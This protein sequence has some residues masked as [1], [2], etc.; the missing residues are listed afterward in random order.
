[1]A[2]PLRRKAAVN[3]KRFTAGYIAERRDALMEDVGQ[4]NAEMDRFERMYRLDVWES[5]KSAEEQRATL[6]I[7]PD[8]IEKE[9]SLLLSR[10]YQISV[11]PSGNGITE[12]DRA[13]K[14]ERHLYGVT[15]RASIRKRAYHA[16][17]NANCPGAGWIKAVYD[18]QA[19]EDEYPVSVTAPDPRTIYP[20]WDATGER[21]TELCHS[22]ERTRRGIEQEFDVQLDGAPDDPDK[23][24]AWL[25]ECV[26]YTEYWRTETV[27]TSVSEDDELTPEGQEPEEDEAPLVI[28]LAAEDYMRRTA[29]TSA[30]AATG[31]DGMPM[32]TIGD[33]L[34]TAPPTDLQEEE[35]P[36]KSKRAPKR[37]V[38]KIIH[39]IIC[40][41]NKDDEPTVIKAPVIVLGY[42]RIPYF[43]W[44]GIETPMAGNRRWLSMLFPATGG[45]GAKNATGVLQLYNLVVSL[46]LDESVRRIHAP[47]ITD[48]DTAEIDTAPDAI[49]TTKP[50]RNVGYLQPPPVNTSLLNVS[51][52][53][54]RMLDR[55]GPPEVWNGQAFNLSGQA[56]SGLAN[57]YQTRIASK[58]QVIE[59]VLC[60]LY[61]HILCI[62]AFYADPDEGWRAYGTGHYGKFV[63]EA[64]TADDIG[65]QYRVIV[66][67]SSSMPKDEIALVSLFAQLLGNN[68]IS[69]ETFLDQFQKLFGMAADSP[70]DEIE[71]TF[72][73]ML[74]REKGFAERIA[75]AKAEDF[76]A[77]LQGKAGGVSLADIERAENLRAMQPPPPP[78]PAPPVM[79]RP[80][81]PGQGSGLPPGAAPPTPDTLAANGNLAGAM[82]MQGNPMPQMLSG[83]PMQGG[84]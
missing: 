23:L 71:R 26:L 18:D 63:D 56:I 62:T 66:K 53:M 39:S 3:L 21:L 10:P 36:R 22:Y 16:A 64:V 51:D 79:A 77:L 55:V 70:E 76:V 17:W 9:R 83:P 2:K 69:W 5:P 28:Q 49:N 40:D 46:Y 37:R 45:D 43:G 61:E 44:G 7:A 57:A 11:P 65:D 1:M 8:I 29:A 50:G 12:R 19:S 13:Q 81:Q 15:E 58:Q 34:E 54:G 82:G 25:D 20:V 47:I 4:R 72:T 80:E 14:L 78:K 41:G 38:K 75:G 52:I 84:M 35:T 60:E 67:L 33:Y 48:D 31:P 74:L 59:K 73:Y 68:A 6:P 30:P 27:L 42:K 24:D 32:P